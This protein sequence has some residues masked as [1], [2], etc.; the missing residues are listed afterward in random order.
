MR[1]QF[2]TAAV[3]SVLAV[4]STC[5]AAET[6]S[7]IDYA[8]EISRLEARIA[9]LEREQQN[10]ENKSTK[11]EEK[12][13]KLEEKQA[14][15]S[16]VKFSGVVAQKAMK[17][18]NGGGTWWEKELFL[19]VDSEIGSGWRIHSGLDWKWGKTGAWN[20]EKSF[21]DTYGNDSY[22]VNAMIYQLN[23]AGPIGK[24][25]NSTL[26]LFTPSLQE[27]YVSNARVKGAEVDYKL[28]DT[29]ISAYTGIVHEKNDDLSSG[30]GWGSKDSGFIRSGSH[31]D[32][33]NGSNL[34]DAQK[35]ANDR[36]IR[37]TGFAVSHKFSPDTSAGIGYYLYKSENAYGDSKL[38]IFALNGRQKVAENVEL[39]AFYSH[40]NRG[41]QNK[42]YDLKA[43]Y[44]GS[45]WGSKKWGGSLGYRYIGSD[46]VIMSSVI[47]GSEKPG[48]KGLEASLW[49]RFTPSIQVQNYLFFGKAIDSVARD[50]GAKH[51]AFFSNLMFC[52]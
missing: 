28:G 31:Y 49:Y 3:L 42:A 14:K 13:T 20:S 12:S 8:S 36:R 45:P 10:L 1:K 46:A 15:G 17:G 34:T 44:N 48:S 26:G 6:S 4:A 5:S 23:A 29:T 47:N 32:Y 38:G 51:T 52:F 18:I 9:Q 21:S 11:L 30:G 2:I 16:P 50:N 33:Y 35:I 24:D 25:I 41:Y 27:G 19:N 39:A 40:G 22:D 37:A 7:T 43:I